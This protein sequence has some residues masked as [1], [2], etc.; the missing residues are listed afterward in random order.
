MGENI[1]EKITLTNTLGLDFFFKE[2]PDLPKK[3][4]INEHVCVCHWKDGTITRSFKHESDIFNK[5]LGFLLCCFRHYNAK[6]SKNKQKKIIS[7]IKY[8]CLE[9]Y[10][11]DMFI[12]KTKMTVKQA[13]AYIRDLKVEEPKQKPKHMKEETTLEIEQTV[14]IREDLKEGRFYGSIYCL[15]GMLKYKGKKTKIEKITSEGNYRLIDC[16]FIWSKEMFKEDK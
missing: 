13:E 9:D 12:E 11:F 14:T 15:D 5:K 10:L 1:F 8:E 16:P 2:E 4:I 6:I 3:Y 7:W